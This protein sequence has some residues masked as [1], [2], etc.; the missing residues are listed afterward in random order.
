M[1][2][3]CKSTTWRILTTVNLSTVSD[4]SHIWRDICEK[5][6]HKLPCLTLEMKKIHVE[7][8]NQSLLSSHTDQKVTYIS[9]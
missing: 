2:L 6:D 4:L 8:H 5:T 1:R 3:F 9:K 7:N